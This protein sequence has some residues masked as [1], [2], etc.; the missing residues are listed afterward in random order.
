MTKHG[1][2]GR[3]PRPGRKATHSYVGRAPIGRAPLPEKA[4]ERQACKRI[5]ELL[6]RSASWKN[7]AQMQAD[8]II[9][10]CA[11]EGVPVSAIMQGFLRRASDAGTIVA[12]GKRMAF[13]NRANKG[14]KK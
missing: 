4:A 2:R 12:V 10:I 13:L 6:Q 7:R 8:Q 9:H 11:E 1:S 3:R 14:A 5:T